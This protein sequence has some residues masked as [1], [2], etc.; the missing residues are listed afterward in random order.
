MS[1]HNQALFRA[2]FEPRAVA[3]IGAS[4][5]PAKNTG[6][7]QRFLRHHGYA[8]RVLP[9]N[10][11]REQVQGVPAYPSVAAAP[12]PID[13]A[14][15]MVPTAAVPAAL[16]DCAAAGVPVVSIFTDGFADSGVQ[17]RARQEA[18]REQAHALGLRVLG[19]NSMGVMNLNAGM[20]LT[21]NAVL[22]IPEIKAGHVSL[23][24]QSGSLLGTMLSRGSARGIGFAK[25]LSVGNE[26]D[27]GVGE[28]VDLLVDDEHTQSIMLFLEAL[29]DADR[30]AEA[31]RR[32]H[33][34]GKPIVVYKLGRSEV[35]RSL[36]AT[37]SGAMLVGE[38]T[39]DTFF[40]AHGM[41]RVDMLETLF[42]APALMQSLLG[43]PR[44]GRGRRVTVMTTT[45]GGAATVVDRLGQAGVE[46]V[47]APGEVAE[48]VATHGVD[49][50]GKPI[51]DLTMAGTRREVFEPVL[52]GLL[53][54]PD[55]DLV[56]VVV[57]S[58]GQFHPELTVEPIAAVDRTRK[59][60]A[61]FILPDAPRSLALLTEQGIAA[62]RTPEGCADAVRACL[63]WAPPRPTVSETPGGLDDARALLRSAARHT[64]PLLDEVQAGQVF[65]ALGVP[66]PASAVID[67]SDRTLAFE[68]PV[69]VKL[70][71]NR[72][73]HKTEVG[74][75]VLGVR[76]HVE[77]GDA[78]IRIARSDRDVHPDLAIDRY[79]V[80]QMTDGVCEAIVGYRLDPEVGPVVTVGAGGRT[81]ELY[82]DIAIRL[83]PVDRRQAHEMLLEVKAF[84]L[85]RGF[86]GLPRADE[87][88]LV[89]AVVAVSHLALVDAPKV[90]EAEINPLLVREA[91]QG[92]SALDAVIRLAEAD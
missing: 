91:G 79:L 46:L 71:S 41:L 76:S 32:A 55:S 54:D 17:G 89:D 20:P 64:G 51:V 25:L 10:P 52:Q 30:L 77:L 87:P 45:G 31:A 8:G 69:A 3:L 80:Q 4:N 84:A 82:R 67:D 43:T 73:T 56:V 90:V 85:L 34:A 63:A 29:R 21:V 24:S 72:V 57:G 16:D 40:R 36:A 75:V 61:V 53:D 92:V 35:G 26:A 15:I 6:R 66:R 1:A 50:A 74:G 47:P 83:A 59:P 38:E 23:V 11:G 12:G 78:F 49:V 19:P 48:L 2:L 28:L 44:S 62:F 68:F 9:I 60:L 70:L 42:E 18:L 37:H 88:A 27:I 81:A 13:H 5:D 58:S 39:A 33:A 22:E 86:R 14:L 65:E 7:P